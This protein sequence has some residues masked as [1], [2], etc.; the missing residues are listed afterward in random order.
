MN[1][2][3]QELTERENSMKKV[4]LMLLLITGVYGQRSDLS[5]QSTTPQTYKL[6]AEASTAGQKAVLSIYRDGSKE[7]VELAVNGSQMITLFDFQAH[8]VCWI[9]WFNSGM[10]SAGRYL[11]S[12]APGSQDPI[13]GTADLLAQLPGNRNHKLVRM[14]KVNGIPARMEEFEGGTKPASAD[15][16][17]A[18]VWFAEPGNFLLKLEG[19]DGNGKPVVLFEVKQF[20]LEKPGASLFAPPA[21][22]PMTDSEMDDSG[23]I[24]AHAEMKTSVKV[25][26]SADLNK[27]KKH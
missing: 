6:V 16:W 1:F 23:T 8:K 5:A 18:R 4:L 12:R 17:P 24:R 26:G 21:D 13:T 2:N 10:C 22:C 25:D 14:E 9:N 15:L 20:S 7:R 27:D 3:S 11:S 19:M